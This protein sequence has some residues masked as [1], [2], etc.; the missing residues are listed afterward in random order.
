MK[1]I[2][3]KNWLTHQQDRLDSALTG[4]SGTWLT[5]IALYKDPR[6]GGYTQVCVLYM[7]KYEAMVTPLKLGPSIDWVPA[8]SLWFPNKPERS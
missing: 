7:N 5:P 3:T 8:K 6:T 4:L 2:D 1:K